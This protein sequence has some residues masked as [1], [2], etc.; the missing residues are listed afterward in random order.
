L[1]HPISQLRPG[2]LLRKLGK[3]GGIQTVTIKRWGKDEDSVKLKGRQASSSSSQA[4]PE[5]QQGLSVGQGTP[6]SE[7]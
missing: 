3:I 2:I 7:E 5:S 6:V 4:N 1:D